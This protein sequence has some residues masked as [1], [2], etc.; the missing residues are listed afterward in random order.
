VTFDITGVG[1]EYVMVIE[2]ATCSEVAILV[3]ENNE[4]NKIT[5]ILTTLIL[6]LALLFFFMMSL[7]ITFYS[8]YNLNTYPSCFSPCNSFKMISAVHFAAFPATLVHLSTW[9]PA[10]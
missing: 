2:S 1:N 7:S 3:T 9:A 8:L 5:E 6:P 10:L 4:R